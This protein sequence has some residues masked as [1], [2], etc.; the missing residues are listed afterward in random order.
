M[1]A[2]LVQL[3][4]LSSTPGRWQSVPVLHGT[5]PQIESSSQTD[6]DTYS[7]PLQQ[8]SGSRPGADDRKGGMSRCMVEGREEKGRSSELLH[9]QS[10]HRGEVYEF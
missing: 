4:L 6:R 1:V 7:F 8:F 10:M 3:P 2:G 5:L 9:G